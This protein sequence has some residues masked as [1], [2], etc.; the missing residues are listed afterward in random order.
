MKEL[1]IENVTV[2]FG[3]ENMDVKAIH[4]YLSE[5]SYWAKGIGLEKVK[6]SLENSFCAGAFIADKQIGFVRAVTDYST[7]AWVSDVYVL[8]AYSGKGIGQQMLK[9]FF[10][11]EWFGELRRIMLAT[12]DAHSLYGKFDFTSLDKP[13]MFMQVLSD[14]FTLM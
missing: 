2:R 9:E 7:F 5:E 4:R 11:Q 14:K 1:T 8:E 13:D 10:A 3:A 12:K 6:S